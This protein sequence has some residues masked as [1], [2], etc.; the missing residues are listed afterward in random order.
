MVPLLINKTA[1]TRSLEDLFHVAEKE[2]TLEA[3]AHLL[4]AILQAQVECTF[5]KINIHA[6]MSPADV[7]G[8]FKP[9]FNKAQGLHEAYQ[10]KVQRMK[11]DVKLDAAPSRI[12]PSQSSFSLSMTDQPEKTPFITVSVMPVASCH[13]R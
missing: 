9:I 1:P 13:S 12:R 5:H 6:A 11:E 8:H 4:N 10:K 7:K 2:N 3:T